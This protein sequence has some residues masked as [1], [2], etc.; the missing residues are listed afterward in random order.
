MRQPANEDQRSSPA[1]PA[2][3]D[4]GGDGVAKIQD[5]SSGERELAG[6]NDDA[7]LGLMEEDDKKGEVRLS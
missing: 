6:S 7:L 2:V 1:E 4:G 3:V 5:V